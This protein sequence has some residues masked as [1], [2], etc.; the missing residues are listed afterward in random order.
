MDQSNDAIQITGKDSNIVV[1][2]YDT[3]F[4]LLIQM[5]RCIRTFII[6]ITTKK[7]DIKGKGVHGAY[8]VGSV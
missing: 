3:L 5:R 2:G 8:I 6:Q 4:R 7:D 1:S